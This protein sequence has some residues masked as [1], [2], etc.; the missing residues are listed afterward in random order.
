MSRILQTDSIETNNITVALKSKLPI[1][2][3][4]SPSLCSDIDEGAGLFFEGYA[5]TVNVGIATDGVRRLIIS[6]DGKVGINTS[7]PSADLEVNGRFKSTFGDIDMLNT[8]IVGD[9]RI[10]NGIGTINANS[11]T[12]DKIF[13]R[14][15]EGD[16]IALDTITYDNIKNNTITNDKLANGTISTDKIDQD[17]I[18]ALDVPQSFKSQHIFQAKNLEDDVNISWDLDVAQVAYVTLRANRTLSNPLN[19]RDGG[20]Y[21]L[22]VKQDDV[23]G[24]SLFY[25][26]DYIFPD[27]I[28]AQLNG[29][30]NRLDIFSFVSLGGKMYGTYAINY[31]IQ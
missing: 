16:K 12:N 15:I 3:A 2:T 20:I 13:S 24:R 5:N 8:N 10:E 4:N 25:G 9:F 7:I 19:Q 29:V 1:S 6:S 17:K 23:G 22:I 31:S 21:V 18:A 30:A 26:T 11:I 28:Q 27:N 14:T